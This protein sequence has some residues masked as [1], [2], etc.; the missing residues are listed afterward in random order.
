MAKKSSTHAVFVVLALVAVGI[1]TYLF[2]GRSSTEHN[3]ALPGG[4]Y[5]RTCKD[6]GMSG[7]F[8]ICNCKQANGKYRNTGL[9]ASLCKSRPISN[10][11]GHLA[12]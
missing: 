8:L 10:L 11:L 5:K 6:C 7:E 4:S 12:C 2:V 9:K 1:A 3:T